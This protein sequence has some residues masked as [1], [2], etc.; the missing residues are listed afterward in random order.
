MMK[1]PLKTIFLLFI[2]S[3]SFASCKFSKGHDFANA[4]SEWSGND[5]G[6][7]KSETLIG[8]FVVLKNKKTGEY[9]AYDL[10][11]YEKG[12]DTNEFSSFFSG[13]SS[14]SIVHNLVKGIDTVI[15]PVTEWVDTSHYNYEWVYDEG[16]QSYIQE[17]V[18]IKDGHWQTY[19]KQTT[20]IVYRSQSGLVFE[21]GAESSKDL[22]K[23][24]A[25]LEK[26][27]EKK[28]GSYISDQYGLSEKRGHF[29]AKLVKN[30]QTIQKKRGLTR[31]DLQKLSLSVLG[32]DIDFFEE[33]I[34]KED[35]VKKDQMILKA[36]KINE[37]DPEHMKRLLTDFFN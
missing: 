27:D 23:W 35:R 8:D 34:R 14:G 7:A 37:T 11:D 24:G 29:L 25:L 33:A 16:S 18:W 5:F 32:V 36:S 15:Q 22:E 13:L 20:V 4:L 10:K 26:R 17:Q 2:I 28:L 30:Y 19:D 12:M 21:E 3:L 6:V 1:N 9:S 31:R